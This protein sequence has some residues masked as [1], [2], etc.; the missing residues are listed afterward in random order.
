[1]LPLL[2]ALPVLPVLPVP[3]VVPV[4]PVLALPLEPPVLPVLPVPPAGAA[5]Q[6]R[7]AAGPAS[8]G[9]APCQGREAHAACQSAAPAAWPGE[10][11][12]RM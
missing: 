8:G 11:D 6:L 9:R 7:H 1:V 5:Q 3:A 2:P 10:R 12:G 4:P